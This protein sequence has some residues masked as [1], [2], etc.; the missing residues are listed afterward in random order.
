MSKRSFVAVDTSIEVS[1]IL[2]LF[3]ARLDKAESDL[4][5]L[6]KRKEGA[7]S[8][9]RIVLWSLY[10]GSVKSFLPVQV[11]NTLDVN[12]S[13]IADNY[14]VRGYSQTVKDT[15]SHMVDH[16]NPHRVSHQS[17]TDVSLCKSHQEIDAAFVNVDVIVDEAVEALGRHRANRNNP[18]GVT[19]SLLSDVSACLSHPT[20]DAMLTLLQQKV[21][22]INADTRLDEHG[23]AIDQIQSQ[24]SLVKGDQV[25]NFLHIAARGNPHQVTHAQLCDG[26]GRRTHA[27]IDA[28]IE[29]LGQCYEQHVEAKGNVHGVTHAMLVDVTGQF[30]HAQLDAKISDMDVV[31]TNLRMDVIPRSMMR[32][33]D[34]NLI[35]IYAPFTVRAQSALD[36]VTSKEVKSIDVYSDNVRCKML[37]V[38][39]ESFMDDFDAQTLQPYWNHEGVGNIT[40]G[41][42]PSSVVLNAYDEVNWCVLRGSRMTYNPRGDYLCMEVRAAFHAPSATVA[43]V[44]LGFYSG[45]SVSVFVAKLI[46]G[47]T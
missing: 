43:S 8:L 24:L 27:T 4:Y 2:D 35:E 14:V 21:A 19:H 41:N 12:R 18:H 23:A 31:L 32:V 16:T 9:S 7:S 15:I 26:I 30:S 38:E 44:A 28:D 34:G 47:S 33:V 42:N 13:V 36:Y 25:A 1:S 37:E 6:N 17:L 5:D 22:V 20:I 3:S 46:T 10:A 11:D 29:L 45:S 39:Y 40:F